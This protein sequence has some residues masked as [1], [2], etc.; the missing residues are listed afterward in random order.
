MKRRA[1]ALALGL[2]VTG[3]AIAAAQNGDVFDPEAIA[4]RER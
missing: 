4:A 3:G 1:I 2:A